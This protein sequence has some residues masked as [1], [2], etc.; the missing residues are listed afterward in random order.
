M[1][2]VNTTKLALQKLNAGICNSCRVTKSVKQCSRILVAKF[3]SEL[4]RLIPCL[5]TLFS[6]L[7]RFRTS[8]PQNFKNTEEIVL[9]VRSDRSFRLDL[10]I[11]FVIGLDLVHQQLMSCA[12]L[13]WRQRSFFYRQI[14][15]HHQNKHI[16]NEYNHIINVLTKILIKIQTYSYD[17]VSID[18]IYRLNSS[19]SRIY[20]MFT[21]QLFAKFRRN[22]RYLIIFI[23][24]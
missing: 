1:M 10:D 15:S 19:T 9:D 21:K 6:R 23:C 7:V 20:Y 18:P 24:S 17:A 8:N 13:H 4:F 2:S 11:W 3:V 22:I 5:L 16:T 12:L 14:E